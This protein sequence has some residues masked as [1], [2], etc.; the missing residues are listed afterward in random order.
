MKPNQHKAENLD[1]EDIKLKKLNQIVNGEKLSDLQL[2]FIG[3]M[4]FSDYY[5]LDSILGNGAFGVVLK[6]TE[7][8]TL[9]KF[10]MKVRSNFKN[11]YYR[12]QTWTSLN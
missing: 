6:V 9:N 5:T 12:N 10:A 4:Y 2:D 7:C 1:E 11:S 8:L 3:T